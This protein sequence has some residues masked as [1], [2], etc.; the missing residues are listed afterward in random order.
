MTFKR[1]VVNK[2]IV[3]ENQHKLMKIIP[4]NIIYKA[5]KG[6]GG[7]SET[8]E[9]YQKFVVIV[10]CSKDGF[11]YV[12]FTYSYLMIPGLKIHLCEDS[13]SL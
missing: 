11:R 10:V 12:F 1:R 13:C 7:I 8:K 2:D 4:K 5:L 3:E 6:G 9:H